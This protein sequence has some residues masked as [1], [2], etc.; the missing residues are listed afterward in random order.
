MKGGGRQMGREMQFKALNEG[1]GRQMGRE[2]GECTRINTAKQDRLAHV[3]REVK[4]EDEHDV[5]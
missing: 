4:A 5:R 3:P 2:K 1:G